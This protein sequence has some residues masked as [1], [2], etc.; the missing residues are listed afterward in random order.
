MTDYILKSTL[1]LVILLAV[2][3]LFLEKEK[4]HRFNRYFL[5]LSLLLSL[6]IPLIT[7]KV[8]SD[9]LPVFANN[10]IDKQTFIPEHLTVNINPDKTSTETQTVDPLFIVVAIYGIGVLFLIVRF[11]NNLSKILSA[12]SHNEQIKINEGVIVLVKEKIL[13]HTFLKY[14]FFNE[15]E[16]LSKNIDDK[17]FTHELTHVT[18]K[19]SADILLIELLRILFWFNPIFILYKKAIQLN[20]EFLADEAVVHH[21]DD[22]ASYQQ[23]LLDKL[24]FVQPVNL[25]SNL[26]HSLTKK[27]MMMMKKSTPKSRA[28]M[29]KIALAPLFAMLVFLFSDKAT[30]LSIIKSRIPHFQKKAGVIGPDSSKDIYYKEAKVKYRNKEGALVIKNYEDMS[31]GEKKSMPMPLQ[32]PPPKRRSPTESF[33]NEWKNSDKFGIWIDGKQIAN[34]DLNVYKAADF[35]AYFN[36]RLTKKAQHYGNRRFQIDLYSPEYFNKSFMT[37]KN[38]PGKKI[39]I[40]QSGKIPYAVK[41]SSLS[42]TN[43]KAM[44]I[45]L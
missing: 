27:R 7:L 20:H 19:H 35:A 39:V 12:A 18:Q 34:K 15:D 43:L 23:L 44:G 5:L 3:H 24:L 26:T 38:E 21:F 6:V 41:V 45:K 36:S 28:M 13:P 37:S 40:V 11:I 42:D 33:L 31:D 22:V 9:P 8:S 10:V 25:S 2:Y 32:F 16:Y 17:L 29:K 30:A 4:M 14:I 1:C